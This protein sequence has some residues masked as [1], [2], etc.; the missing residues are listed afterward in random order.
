MASTDGGLRAL[1]QLHV[2]IVTPE[3]KVFSGPAREV[4]VP[5]WEGQLGVFPDH[6]ALLSL[7]KAGVCEVTTAEGTKK[8][9][10]GRGFADIGGDHVTLLTDQAVPVSEI[11]KAAA[12]TALADAEKELAELGP[13]SEKGKL[14]AQRIE[15]AQ[16][17][18]D[19]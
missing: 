15:W 18:L 17:L 19:A 12:Q 7:L 16:A 3:A 9:I 10:I 8:W 2:D 4:L 6:D 1:G 13:S 5:A 11:D 14:V